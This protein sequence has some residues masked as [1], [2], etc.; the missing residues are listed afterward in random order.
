MRVCRRDVVGRRWSGSE[1]D[2]LGD[3]VLEGRDR[4]RRDAE[5]LG[6]LRVPVA[7]REQLI[8]AQLPFGQRGQA[9]TFRGAHCCMGKRQIPARGQQQRRRQG[10]EERTYLPHA[11]KAATLS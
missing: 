9:R 4:L 1:P 8:H 7:L 6:D 3:T 11:F 2:L 5:A 10:K